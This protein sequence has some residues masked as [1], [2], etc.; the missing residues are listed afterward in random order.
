MQRRYISGEELNTHVT[1]TDPTTTTPKHHHPPHIHTHTR[2]HTHTPAHSHEAMPTHAQTFRT[3]M[4]KGKK[5]DCCNHS[6]GLNPSL[7]LLSCEQGGAVARAWLRRVDRRSVVVDCWVEL[8][9]EV[10]LSLHARLRQAVPVCVCVCGGG[11]S[12]RGERVRCT[13][14]ARTPARGSSCG[15]VWSIRASK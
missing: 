10:R 9:F 14:H 7:I 12:M 13:L 2:T 8:Q 15:K 6:L 5:C 3:R 4:T 1:H 11:G